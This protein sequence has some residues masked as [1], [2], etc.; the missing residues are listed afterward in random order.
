MP[1]SPEYV[2]DEESIMVGSKAMAAVSVGL[3]GKARDRQLTASFWRR[4][5]WRPGVAR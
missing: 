1:H 4:R 2:A 3:S 5:A